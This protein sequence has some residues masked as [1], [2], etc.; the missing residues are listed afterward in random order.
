MRAIQARIR[1]MVELPAERRLQLHA[2]LIERSSYMRS[3]EAQAAA[4]R[5]ERMEA[6]RALVREMRNEV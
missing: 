1:E 3:P 4:R 6:F 2:D 5:P